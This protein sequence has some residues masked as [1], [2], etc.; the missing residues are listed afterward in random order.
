MSRMATEHCSRCNPGEP[1]G[2]G[3]VYVIQLRAGPETKE[4]YKGFLYVGKTGKSVDERF[5]DTFTRKDRTIVP[6]KQ[7][8]DFEED[9]LWKYNT[10]Y[11]KIIRSHYMRHR[12][13]LHHQRNPIPRY[14]E[15]V[16]LNQEE[17]RLANDLRD[18]GW[19]V[20]QA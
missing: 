20:H 12:P 8:F 15:D 1:C 6:I 2:N 7:A 11:S 19:L 3:H 18:M 17:N 9:G 5:E 16:R 13:D 10:P 14:P 4:R